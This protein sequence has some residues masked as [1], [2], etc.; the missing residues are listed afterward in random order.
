ML[1]LP[2]SET[3]ERGREKGRDSPMAYLHRLRYEREG[4]VGIRTDRSRLP[5][6]TTQRRLVGMEPRTR[7]AGGKQTGQVGRG[8]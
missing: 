8:V 2:Q 6:T 1:D 7:L 3:Q 4:T 5:V